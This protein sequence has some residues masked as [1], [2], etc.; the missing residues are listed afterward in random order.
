MFDM[1]F[2]PD[3]RRQGLLERP[4]AVECL[5]KG[6]QS[7]FGIYGFSGAGWAHLRTG[8]AIESTYATVRLRTKRTKGCRSR[9]GDHDDGVEVGAGGGEPWLR[10]KGFKLIPPV[11]EDR[12]G[13][14]P[15][16][17]AVSE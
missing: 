4:E 13:R 14:R 16:R 6:E 11:M 12:T 2:I 9:D 17:R 5:R 7:L 8:N 1:G 15:D 10:L 3:V